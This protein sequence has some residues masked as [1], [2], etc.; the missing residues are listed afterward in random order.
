MD[1]EHPWMEGGIPPAALLR[2]ACAAAARGVP[3]HNPVPTRQHTVGV[4]CV[5]VGEACFR[6][7]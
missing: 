3:L 4:M 7:P 1:M 6:E 2:A 5:G